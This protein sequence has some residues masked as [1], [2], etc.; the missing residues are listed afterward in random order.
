[1]RQSEV[2]Q[3]FLALQG[4][5]TFFL[6]CLF[7]TLYARLRRQEFFW[8][9]SVAWTCYGVFLVAGRGAMMLSAEWMV[10]RNSLVL[11]SVLAGFAKAPLLLF[12]VNTLPGIGEERV[13]REQP[14]FTP[15]R[16]L[17]FLVVLGLGAASYAASLILSTSAVHSYYLRQAGRYGL[18]L[19]TYF[20]CAYAF[21]RWFRQSR[22]AG[23]LVAALASFMGALVQMGFAASTWMHLAPGAATSWVARLPQL[24]DMGWLLLDL[25]WEMG[26]GLAM[27]LVLVGDHRRA[28]IA[29]GH[30]EAK[31]ATIFHQTRQF[32]LITEVGSGRIV[33]ANAAFLR[34]SRYARQELVGQA[35]AQVNL[36]AEPE[37]HA[38]IM[39]SLRRTGTVP[40][41]ETGLR[42]KSGEVRTTRISITLIELDHVPCTMMMGRDVTEQRDA[43]RQIRER[44]ELLNALIQNNPLAIVVIDA[45]ERIQLVNAAFEILFRYRSEEAIG[46]NLDDLI[47]PEDLKGEALE[48][49]QSLLSGKTVHTT[50][51]RRRRDGGLV[52]VELYGVPMRTGDKVVGGYAIYHDITARR[53]A[54]EL[55]RESEERYRDLFENASDL[56]FT[57]SPE[58][59]LIY[60]NRAWLQTL[61]Y[62]HAE[63]AGL[64]VEKILAPETREKFRA[65]RD[66]AIRTQATAAFDGQFVT[67]EGRSISVEGSIGHRFQD[68]RPV[69]LRAIFRDVSQRKYAEE[70]IRKLNED[71]EHRVL[72]RT[73]Q[74]AAVN[75]ELEAR[76]REV[77]RA[78]RLKSQFLA[79][80]SHELRTP[81]NAVIGFSDLLN[82]ETA[83]PLNEKQKRYVE[84]V[85]TGARNLLQLINDILDLSKV[86]AGQLLLRPESFALADALPE[87]LSTIKPLA[88]S[89]QIQ[90]E[91]KVPPDVDLLVDR[92]RLKQV[93]YNLLSNAIKF[94]PD[95]GRV[96][97][98]ARDLGQQVLLSVS[99]TGIG[100]PP[101]EHEAIFNEF[102]QVGMTTKGV[103]E[104]TGLGLAISRRLVEAHGGKIW[105]ESAPGQGS[106]FSFTLPQGRSAVAS[107]TAGHSEA[108][109]AN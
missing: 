27:I 38:R 22:S 5:S 3:V 83:G 78:N 94:T 86:E 47:A 65:V 46:R 31:F 62:T 73:A 14:Q 76:N 30:S 42:I 102:H 68:N 44:T 8:W 105:V 25:C 92:I 16:W 51:R 61:G 80:M 55:L 54:E 90:V 57:A 88:M 28:E 104:G 82:E 97:I 50:V 106:T 9:W 37:V 91:N 26:I 87:V 108:E 33:E 4:L 32:V 6:I 10:L 2:L 63:I 81:L 49:S 98:E 15:Q 60:V 84:H 20:Y 19:L 13:A 100:I 85:L 96:R 39:E 21:F 34:M 64:T 40:D 103:R 48:L 24:S 95:G 75:R 11:L 71:L 52:D 36:W 12:G 107:A 70:E 17:V 29:K 101:E 41:F 77:E 23:A 56:V 69:F 89:K 58:G 1:M 43:E 66:N 35:A 74:L 45:D 53:L 59:A 67:K 7:W 109:A 18:L 72:E 93:L 79:S 99:D